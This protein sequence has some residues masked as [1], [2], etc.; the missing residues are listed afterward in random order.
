MVAST[1]LAPP[2]LTFHLTMLKSNCSA[3]I[4]LCYTQSVGE[5]TYILYGKLA[6][7][8]RPCTAIAC[9]RPQH[10]TA[11]RNFNKTVACARQQLAGAEMHF[12][13]RLLRAYAIRCSSA[14]LSL[15]RVITSR[16]LVLAVL[17]LLACANFITALSVIVACTPCLKN[18]ACFS[19]G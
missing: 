12:N 16:I 10:A 5:P 13:E 11:Y 8:G 15:T 9:A 7:N 3:D 2:T 6:R 18:P 17:S 14:N 1:A 4:C 19:S